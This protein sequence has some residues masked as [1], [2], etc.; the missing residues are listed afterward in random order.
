MGQEN[1]KIQYS[2]EG[3][4]FN[5]YLPGLKEAAGKTKWESGIVINFG[6]LDP[7][8]TIAVETT[9]SDE[10]AHVKKIPQKYYTHILFA[11]EES[12]GE[13]RSTASA[14]TTTTTT[15]YLRQVTK[16]EAAE[17]MS[18]RK[19]P[20]PPPQPNFKYP[21]RVNA[22]KRTTPSDRI[23]VDDVIDINNAIDDAVAAADMVSGTASTNVNDAGVSEN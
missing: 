2:G 23:D 3:V 18:I 22:G 5:K 21:P 8:I 17:Y 11:R 16:E 14:A 10:S 7:L 19:P 12:G 4:D 1:S 20:P 9:T 6:T 13:S 15:V